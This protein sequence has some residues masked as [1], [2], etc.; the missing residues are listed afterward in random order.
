MVPINDIWLALIPLGIYQI[1][2][3]K[4]KN[5]I[6]EAREYDVFVWSLKIQIK[7]GGKAGVLLEKAAKLTQ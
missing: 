5:Y 1:L 3:A 7:S 2:K 4:E 6:E